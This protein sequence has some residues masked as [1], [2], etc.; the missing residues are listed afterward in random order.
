MNQ[1]ISK[2]KTNQVAIWLDGEQL[3]LNSKKDL[4]NSDLLELIK[5][6][7][8]SLTRLL[9][10]NHIYSKGDFINRII[11][12]TPEEKSEL[13]FA[14]ERLLFI[15][16]WQQGSNAYHIPHLIRLSDDINYP[17][18]VDAIQYM[19]R[20][21]PILN[22]IYRLHENGDAYQQVLDTPLTI[23]CISKKDNAALLNGLQE[24]IE[25]DFDLAKGRPFRVIRLDSPQGAFVLFVWHHIAFDG[26]SAQI[27]FT[28]LSH[29]YSSYCLGQEPQ[30]AQI[31]IRYSDYAVWQRAFLQGEELRNLE[32]YW[33]EQLNGYSSLHLFTDRPRPPQLDYRGQILKF[34]LDTKL[35]HQLRLL[36]REQKTTLYS[37]MLSGFYLLLSTLSGQKDLV[38]GT[39]SENR[40]HAQ[41][42]GVI[43]FFVNL[44]ALRGEIDE[45]F[46]IAQW[47]Y[48]VHQL[49]LGAKVHQELPFERLVKL[50]N[51][52]RDPSRH[53]LFQVV[54]SLENTSS[55]IREED[56]NL[57][58]TQ[59]SLSELNQGLSDDES[60]EGMQYNQEYSPAK[61]DLSLH[62]NDGQV[63]LDGF[64]NFSTSLFDLQTIT[65]FSTLYQR[66]LAEIV[67]DVQQPIADMDLICEQERKTL[68]VDWV[69]TTPCSPQNL[70]L[71]QLFEIQARSFADKPA[72][73]FKQQTLSY[74]QLN[75]RANQ[76]ALK[77]QA[78]Y[79]SAYG[80][81]LKSGT[82]IGIFLDHSMEM[83]ISIIAILKTGCAYVPISPNYPSS[84]TLYIL[85]DT[86]VPIVITDNKYTGTFTALSGELELTPVL[87]FADASV[88][89]ADDVSLIPVSDI[90]PQ[91]LAYVIY[92]S[93]TTGKPKGVLQ[94]HENVMRLLES[95]RA[96]LSFD[97]NDT[98]VLYHSYTFDFSVWELWGALTT[99]GK[100][101]VPTT[102]IKTDLPGFVRLCQQEQVTVL[103]QTP[104]AF[105]A[106]VD[107]LRFTGEPLVLLRLVILGG[108]KLNIEQLKEWWNTNGS[109]SIRLVNMYGLTETTV[110]ATY[111]ELTV[112]E[113]TSRSNIG[114]PLKH[115]KAYVLNSRLKP[116]PIGAPGELH[117]GG[118][119]LA[120]EYLNRAELTAEKF[121]KNPF[122]SPE[123]EVN[124]RLYKTGDLVRWLPNGE[125]E[126]LGRNDSQVKIRGYRIELGEIEAVLAQHPRVQQ[127]AV[128]DRCQEENK[129]LAAYVVLSEKQ[130]STIDELKAFVSVHLPA[131]MIPTTFTLLD[132][133]PLTISGKLNRNALPLPNFTTVAEYVEPENELER[134]LCL[135]WEKLLGVETIGVLDNFFDL[136][137]DSILLLKV[138]HH[139]SRSN[140][141]VSPKL[142]NEQPTIRGLAEKIKSQSIPN[143]SSC[144]ENEIV[145]FL[146]DYNEFRKFM[147]FNGDSNKTG[148]FLIPAA[149]GPETFI[150][151]VE[152]L[153]IDR[154]VQLLENIQVY[155][156]RQIRLNHLI[157]YY[158]AV[159]RKKQ[160]GGPYFLGGYCEGAM[161]SLGIAQ[162][163]EALGE[164]VEMLFLIDP[165]VITIEQTMID[166]IKQDSRLLECGRFEAEMVDT[167]LFYAE[168][169]KSLQPYG[170]PAIFFEGSSVSDEATPTQ[171]LALINDYIDIQ[172]VFKKGF[173]TPKN[174]FED[175]LLNCDYISIKAKHERVMIEDETLNT[176]AMAIN[177]KLSAGQQTY[178]AP[179]AQTTEM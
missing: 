88:P 85:Q 107:T 59:Q 145:D 157:D 117:I 15:H 37:L 144:T 128:I 41:T 138:Y 105:Y 179:E 169:V 34:S 129:Y 18:L 131:Y 91:D 119:G 66:I 7:K 26:W 38:I 80:E 65:R 158:L 155:S 103:N 3:R 40:H 165:V 13:S 177:R 161:V 147:T 139:C 90:E 19:V 106:L 166:T 125:L 75:N 16:Q 12:S 89:L 123:D 68:L 33:L 11:F 120:R 45:S 95:T 53:P 73:T 9:K 136:G 146:K 14:Q 150:P 64:I 134:E 39:P 25:Q 124:T 176:I 115:M 71:H 63:E 130:E 32:N 29:A 1:L 54:F 137:G 10:F 133:L 76:L 99:G 94:T 132:V 175:L 69:K 4:S 8:S 118:A 30:L 92:T 84:R 122:I 168:Y 172:G 143:F 21:H 154:P 72:L 83:V 49:V 159:I 52:E 60:Q 121:I 56:K 47:I 167:F 81:H 112:D 48:K 111:K 102:E 87:V 36:A 173:S 141:R 58:F 82:L 104:A 153:D 46:T 170:G 61:F 6:Q 126:Y 31:D 22:T 78:D 135:I 127:V 160:P 77:L 110:T 35:S 108:E 57:P 86:E 98:W 113:D 27:F 79:Q 163:L 74:D 42:Q 43:G 162:K 28:E 50:L 5:E 44:L 97:D 174:G 140:I 67:A 62:I 70:C 142:L 116:L 2:I 152:K 171:T 23:R 24:A 148:L 156:G 20:R 96:D 101:V 178:L 151:L 55:K 17:A 114:R 93:G 149:A 164:Q 109:K 51:V 100:L